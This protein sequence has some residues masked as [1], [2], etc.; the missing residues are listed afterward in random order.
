VSASRW[1]DHVPPWL[2]F[3]AVASTGIYEPGELAA[4]AAPLLAALLVEWRQWELGSWR[5][6]LEALALAALLALVGARI[7]LVPSVVV[8]LFLLCGIRLVL[9]RKA[10]QRRQILLM[11]FLIWLTTAISTFELSF[12]LWSLLWVAG[13][14]AVLLQVAWE[15]SAGL[16]HGPLS[17]APLAR[18]PGWALGT[19]ILSSLFF[20][21][22]PRTAL[23][24][25]AFPWGAAGLAG[26][27][28]G[29]SDSLDLGMAGA[30]APNGEVVLRIMPS[31]P[32]SEPSRKEAGAELGLLRGLAL[33]SIEGQRWGPAPGEGL[34]AG[35]Y[36]LEDTAPPPLPPRLG[37]DLFIAPNPEGIIPLPYGRVGLLP[38]QG[39]PAV[40]GP[41][42]GLRWLYPTRRPL[43]LRLVLEPSG[44]LPARPPGGR[45]LALL[46]DTGTGTESA[47]RW[48]RR[49]VPGDLPPVPL[50][51][52]LTRRLRAFAYTLDNPSGSAPNPL[53]DFL[54][55]THAGHCEYFASAL[56]LMLR[57]RGIPARVVNGYRL[58]PW[59]PEGG[60]WL[61]TQNEAHSWVEYYDGATQ[62]WQVADPTPP[63]PPAGLDARTLMASFQRWTDALRFRWDRYVV[64]FS[65][66]DQLAGLERVQGWAA[67]LPDWRPDRGQAAGLLVV[68]VS[69]SALWLLLRRRPS[70]PAPRRDPLAGGAIPALRPLLRA[71]GRDHGP[72]A[73]ET[74]RQWLGR[75]AAAC[76]DRAS[77]LERIA[78]EA[79]SAAYGRGG[80][81][82]LN[83]LVK[84]E[85][86]V[87]RARLRS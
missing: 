79:E 76:P 18:V 40:A 35:L 14:G 21:I 51:E 50:A 6:G 54:E 32:L 64:R 3:G 74:V 62:A 31:P 49:E 46:T 24:L 11:G 44:P 83:S 71:A 63:A 45:R 27:Q 68:I 34:P 10:G 15:G 80:A 23:G 41:G 70:G 67:R 48:S 82:R 36:R 30:I 47:D 20:V 75:L 2:A 25:R 29:L 26:A 58:G 1:I 77:V 38:L 84:A 78:G 12:L 37:L 7:G 16:R 66:Q 43:S 8:M 42:G 56:A 60:Y 19:L 85:A 33:E 65:D 52:Q 28:A 81:S 86:R 17:P 61:V 5:R 13:A 4:M 59:I 72:R 53:Q 22:L 87:L 57:Y 73:G 39:M 9:P 69:A 55:R